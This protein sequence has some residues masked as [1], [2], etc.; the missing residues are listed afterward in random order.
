MY[1]HGVICDIDNKKCSVD[2]CNGKYSTKGFCKKHY[3]QKFISGEPVSKR[4]LYDKTKWT[5]EGC[6]AKYHAAG[7]CSK[8]Y[9]QIWEFGVIRK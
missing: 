2:G 4:I 3:L 1:R 6:E 5:V 8:H 9:R 7:Y